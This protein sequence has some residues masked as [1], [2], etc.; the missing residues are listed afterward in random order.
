MRLFF[1]ILVLGSVSIS[2]F[3]CKT[4]PESSGSTCKL[5]TFLND[6]IDSS[7]KPQDDFFL[8]TMGK[9]IKN[10][11]IPAAERSWGIW[12]KVNEENYLRLKSINEE[13]AEKKSETGSNWQKIGDLWT[14]GMDTV[15]IE[16]QGIK[17]LQPELDKIN[18]ISDINSLVKEIGHLQY[19]GPSPFFGEG[20]AQDEKNS[21]K[22]ALHIGQGGLGLPDRDF[23]FDTDARSK[24]IRAEYVIHLEKMFGLL[25]DD[26]ATARANAATVMK[27]ETSMA[28]KSRKLAALRDPYKNYN[29]V[30][31]DGLTKLTPSV[32]WKS[33]FTANGVSSI[34]TVIVGQHEFCVRM[35]ELLMKNPL[36]D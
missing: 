32:D 30:G 1:R 7:V 33:L 31:L 12:S 2:I 22:M 9:W 11:P 24:T 13:A 29:K 16:Q 5:E 17:P 3:S 36:N 25:G 23:Y 8:F 35:Q 27:L 26:T 21:E 28:E 20:V 10:N 4:K 19:I 34:D 15:S 6:Y 14:T 18:E